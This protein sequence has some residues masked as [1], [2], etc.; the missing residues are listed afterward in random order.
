MV[1]WSWVSWVWKTFNGRVFDDDEWRN[2][3]K[4]MEERGGFFLSYGWRRAKAKMVGDEKVP[5]FFLF[6][7]KSSN[8]ANQR[9][10]FVFLKSMNHV[11]RNLQFS[12]S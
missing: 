8:R 7:E 5:L 4:E 11:I 6:R 9:M 12:L 10:T 1:K 2:K 3:V